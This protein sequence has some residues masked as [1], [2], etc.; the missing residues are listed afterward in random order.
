MTRIPLL[1][2]CDFYTELTDSGMFVGRVREFPR[3]RTRPQT[4]A[5]DARTD[6]ITLTRDAIAYM[7]QE[8][9][10]AA[11]KRKRWSTQ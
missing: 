5:L 4:K 7:A 11:L 3:L 9:A 6:I 10:L 1:E 8:Q 2:A